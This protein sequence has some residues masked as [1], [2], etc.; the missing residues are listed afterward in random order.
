M[1]STD[2]DCISITSRS[3]RNYNYM[4]DLFLDNWTLTPVAGNSYEVYYMYNGL[5]KHQSANKY[6]SFNIVI[7][8]DGNEII[9][10]GDGSENSPYVIK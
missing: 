5:A 6:S 4:K 3:C 7:N 9:E 8:I 1:V 2:P 10:S